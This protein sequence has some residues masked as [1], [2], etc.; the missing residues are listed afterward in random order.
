MGF[1]SGMALAVSCMRFFSP[2]ARAIMTVTVVSLHVYPI[3]SCAGIDLQSSAIG[4]GGLQHDRRWMLVTDSGVFMTQRTWPT[5][6]SIRPVLEEGGLCV[7]APGMAALR[8]PIADAAADA[9]APARQLTVWRD[10]I[11]GRDEGDEAA[12]WFSEFLR[13]PCRLYAVHEQA[14]RLADP[15]RVQAWRERHGDQ[16][17]G[18]SEHHAFGF[19]DGFPLLVTSQDSLDELNERLVAR[20]AAPVPMD[21]FRPNIVVRG[22]EP[23]DEDHIPVLLGAD[24]AIALVK[25]CSRCVIPDTDQ[26]TGERHQEPGR[27]LAAYRTWDEGV[28]FGQNA[29]VSAP[30]GA[31][32]RVGDALR[33]EIDF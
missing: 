26:A 11:A 16:A 18:V 6:A 22:L 21:R 17:P 30:P 8:I 10:S 28:M 29:V 12:R 9:E 4:E 14:R 19:A 24:M 7:A 33:A 1:S 23:Y 32:V 3:K 25:P 15:A 31:V 5:M 27:T 13:E 2:L 20:G